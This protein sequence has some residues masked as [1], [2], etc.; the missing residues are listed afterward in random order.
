MIGLTFVNTV[1]PDYDV[2]GCDHCYQCSCERCCTC[3]ELKYHDGSSNYE[4]LSQDN[5]MYEGSDDSGYSSA[6]ESSSDE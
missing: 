3:G 1:L 4:I 5:I 2:S 6:D